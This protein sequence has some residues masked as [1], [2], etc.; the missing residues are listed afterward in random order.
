[1]RCLR[2]FCSSML[3]RAA[4]ILLPV[5]IAGRGPCS[6]RVKLILSRLDG[7][8]SVSRPRSRGPY[9]FLARHHG[10]REAK[11]TKLQ[12]KQ[13][14]S[15][16]ARCQGFLFGTF[17]LGKTICMLDFEHFISLRLLLFCGARFRLG[18]KDTRP[19]LNHVHR[20]PACG[21]G[22][23]FGSR[24]LCCLRL[25]WPTGSHRPVLLLGGVHHAPPSGSVQTF[26]PL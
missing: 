26:P 6:H 23:L 12:T 4:L 24:G 16:P 1:M 20:Y 19:S 14:S 7:H 13:Q 5:S 22:R 25:P 21:C 2:K 10:R 15:V 3:T 11:N 8:T 17:S 18:V 9:P